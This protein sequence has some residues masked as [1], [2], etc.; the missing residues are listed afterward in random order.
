MLPRRRA[1]VQSKRMVALQSKRMV[2]LQSGALP[3]A[4]AT[5]PGLAMTHPRRRNPR[6]TAY[7]S[8]CAVALYSV[9]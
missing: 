3:L 5:A 6:R 9:E 7:G 8:S 4:R 1:G 2:A